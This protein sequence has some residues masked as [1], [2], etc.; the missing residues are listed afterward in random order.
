LT[1]IQNQKVLHELIKDSELVI[2]PGVGHA[3]MYE[4]PMLFVSLVLGFINAKQSK[5]HI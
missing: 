2:L 3:S 4:R 1:P 5:Y